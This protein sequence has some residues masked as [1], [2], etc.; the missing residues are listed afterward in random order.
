[1][2]KAAVER[3]F[4]ENGIEHAERV[5]FSLKGYTVWSYRRNSEGQYIVNPRHAGMP[6][7]D[8]KHYE[9]EDA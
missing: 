3:F 7:L 8:V 1:M 9:Y 5:E 4:E 2:Q 6:I